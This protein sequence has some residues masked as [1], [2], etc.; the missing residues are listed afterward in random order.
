MLISM[1]KIKGIIKIDDSEEDIGN[2]FYVDD[3]WCIEQQHIIEH[4][5]DQGSFN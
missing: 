1:F 2:K 4:I 3:N 5:K